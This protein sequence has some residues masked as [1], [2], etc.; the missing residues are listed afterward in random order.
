MFDLICQFTA[1]TALM[2]N[3]NKYRLFID[4]S[5]D[6][7]VSF[8]IFVD[9]SIY[10]L[11]GLTQPDFASFARQLISIW[12]IRLS[13]SRKKVIKI[14]S[15]AKAARIISFLYCNTGAHTHTTR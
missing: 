5:F 8:I 12:L 15:L 7:H 1:K 4:L 11:S 2:K 13:E 3:I 6:Q 9:V 10:M 14:M